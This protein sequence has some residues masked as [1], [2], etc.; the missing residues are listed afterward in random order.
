MATLLS[1]SEKQPWND[2]LIMWTENFWNKSTWVAVWRNGIVLEKD[3]QAL[4]IGGSSVS[5][6]NVSLCG[7]LFCTSAELHDQCFFWGWSMHI[8][9]CNKYSGAGYAHNG[10]MISPR[11]SD[12]WSAV[13]ACVHMRACTCIDQRLPSKCPQLF[14]TLIFE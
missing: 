13:C 2:R 9:I 3:K 10:P 8:Y 11:M 6:E 1:L 5:F 12:E 7:T 14:C 4:F